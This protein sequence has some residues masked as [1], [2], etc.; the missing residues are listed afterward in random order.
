M[1]N[2]VSNNNS[3]SELRNTIEIIKLK[4]IIGNSP[5]NQDFKNK[6]NNYLFQDEDKFNEELLVDDLHLTDILKII[7]NVTIELEEESFVLFNEKIESDIENFYRNI[8]KPVNSPDFETLPRKNLVYYITPYIVK[9]RRTRDRES[10]ISQAIYD[11]KEKDR[12]ID[13]FT[14]KLM[15]AISYL[16]NKKIDENIENLA[17][18][19]LPRSTVGWISTIQQSIDIIEEWYDNGITDFEY[20]CSKKIINSEGL[21]TRFRTIERSSKGA[22]L[23]EADHKTS[24]RCYFD[25]KLNLNNTAFI[26]MDDITTNGIIMSAC[27]KLL[28]DENIKTE[29]I[30]MLAIGGTRGYYSWRN[31]KK[32]RF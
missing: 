11:Y 23:T 16:S 9:N 20:N 24:I 27:R 2:Q 1:T 30:Y 6:L 8:E 18:V 3:Y 29:N 21:L 19:C 26:L 17:L 31:L 32:Y 7:K 10:I 12:Y 25:S 15:K 13:C 28:E 14:E 22:H 4:R 5:F